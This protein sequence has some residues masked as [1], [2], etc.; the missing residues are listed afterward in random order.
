MGTIACGGR[1]S[2]GR[3]ANGKWPLGAAN[4]R[5]EQYPRATC[6]PSP[7]QRATSPAHLLPPRGDSRGYVATLI[8]L[9]ML[10][11]SHGGLQ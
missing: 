1:G 4:C 3:A 5:R 10:W 7:L 11:P 8:P 9:P 6:Q 2:K